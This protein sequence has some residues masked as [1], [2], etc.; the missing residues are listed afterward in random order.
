[1]SGANRIQAEGVIKNIIREIVQECA[2]RGEGVSETLVAFIIKSIVLEPQNDFQVDRVLA[3]E[4]VQRLIDLCVKRLLDS[5]SASLDTIKMQVYFDMNYTT[6]DEFLTEHRRVLQSRLQP[7]LREITDNRSTTKEEL[8]SLYRKIVSSV[9]LRSGLGS[10]TDI[11]VV[12]EATAALQSVFPQTELGNFLNLS[13][14]DKDRQLVELTQIV[15]GIRLFNKECGKGGEGIDNLPAILNEAIPATLKEIQQ[16]TDDAIDS[17]E[18]LISVLDA[19]NA[20]QHKQLSKET[21]RKRIQESMI[22]SRQL[23]LYL[24][25]LSNDVKQ[26]ARE[27]EELLQQFKFRLEQLKTTIQNKTAVPTAQVY[28]QFMHLASIWF[29]FQDEMVLL[30]VLSNILYSLEPYTLNTKEL[31]ADDAVRKC[32]NRIT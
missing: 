31:L 26:S 30:S 8:E 16:Q 22:N 27:V 6:R 28:P 14:R 23:E 9:L 29:G 7:I 25:I 17:S 24:K 12:R 10:P 32:L 3:S 5:K 21:P 4:D 18:K 15:T 19:M 13:K 2:S 1:M 11:S 20:L